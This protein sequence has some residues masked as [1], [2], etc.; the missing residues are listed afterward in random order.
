MGHEGRAGLDGEGAGTPRV[1]VGS[2]LL[3]DGSRS[4]FWSCSV[5]GG[6][7]L[8]LSTGVSWGVLKHT[9]VKVLFLTKE[10]R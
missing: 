8:G 1:G 7:Q 9:N 10:I 3:G 5:K 4:V 6:L 2:L